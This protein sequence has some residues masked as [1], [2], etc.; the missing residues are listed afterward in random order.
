MKRILPNWP[1][2][3]WVRAISTTRLGGVSKGAF[4]NF[5]LG[6]H[7]NDNPVDVERNRLTLA[8]TLNFMYEPQWLNQTHS[9]EVIELKSPTQNLQA[10]NADGALTQLTGVPCVILTA[11]CLPLLLCDTE[12]TVVGAIHCGWRG[13]SNGIIEKALNAIRLHTNNDILAWLGPCIGQNHFE[14]GDEVRDQFLKH[15][16]SASTAFEPG[17]QTGK[18]MAD[19]V[20]LA[21]QRLNEMGVRQI[22]GGDYCTYTDTQ[23]YSYRRDKETGRMAT[24]IWLAL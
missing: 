6:L 11:D 1:A 7:V 16:L 22:Y 18:W 15:N 5:N 2:P 3:T 10:V 8:Q 4:E 14:V 24:L 12:G 13:I 17:K 19:L 20:M 9:T 23:F 21:R